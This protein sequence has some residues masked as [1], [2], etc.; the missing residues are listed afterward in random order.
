MVNTMVAYVCEM[1]H[2]GNYIQQTQRYIHYVTHRPTSSST[3][4]NNYSLNQERYMEPGI[5]KK[6]KGQLK[7]GKE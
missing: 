2:H 3:E 1:M 5:E 7:E 4:G 6:S